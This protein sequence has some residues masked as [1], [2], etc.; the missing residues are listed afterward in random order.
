M[1]P[2]WREVTVMNALNRRLSLFS[3]EELFDAVLIQAL[4]SRAK[5]GLSV[6]SLEAPEL[7]KQPERFKYLDFPCISSRGVLQ[8]SERGE[9][10]ESLDRKAAEATLYFIR[11]ADHLTFH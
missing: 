9:T 8:V 2:I 4:T 1:S 6:L 7:L 11:M 3:W 5:Q 10:C